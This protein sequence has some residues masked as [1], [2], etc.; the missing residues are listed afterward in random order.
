MQT[1]LARDAHSTHEQRSSFNHLVD[2]YLRHDRTPEWIG[3]GTRRRQETEDR[4]NE[5]W[6][7]LGDFA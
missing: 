1:V 5:L 3:I 2:A 7:Y 6:D 4:T